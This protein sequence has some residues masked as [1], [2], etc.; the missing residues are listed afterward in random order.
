MPK[1]SHRGLRT[2]EP[3]SFHTDTKEFVDLVDEHLRQL[4]WNRAELGQ[5]AGIAK[6]QISVI[7]AEKPSRLIGRK[8][9]EKIALAL[10][11]GYADSN[12]STPSADSVF[13]ELL[14]MAGYFPSLGSTRDLVWT[15]L[16]GEGHHVI[17]A[18]WIPYP[19]FAVDTRAGFAIDVTQRLAE[20]MGVDVDWVPFKKWSELTE[21]IRSRK[22][23][24]ICPVLIKLP[25][26]MLQLRFSEDIPGITIR[27]NGVV[28]S[29]FQ[30]QAVIARGSFKEPNARRL[31]VNYAT[32]EVGE[33]LRRLIAH[34][35]DTELTFDS[36]EEACEYILANPEDKSLNKVRC[37][38]A[39][40]ITCLNLRK[41]NRDAALLLLENEFN[42]EQDV[43]LP[44]AFAVHPEEYKFLDVINT[45]LEIMEPYL[46]Y[47]ITDKYEHELRACHPAEDKQS[48]QGTNTDKEA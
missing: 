3:V 27:V 25:M 46:T 14:G 13:N 24:V 5:K 23:D 48:Q 7:L 20:L 44:V 6:A 18:G 37:L 22:I 16:A 39:D 8:H 2:T 9:A 36:T 1:E 47:L 15:E 42:R 10:A 38:I 40:E 33:T 17:R 41:R 43:R 11:K 19:P 31:L 4:K 45:C 30:S 29:Q 21:A 34:G 26:R 28:H 35:A 12:Q 32:G